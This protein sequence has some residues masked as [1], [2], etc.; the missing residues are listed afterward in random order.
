[1]K[2]KN[3]FSL[4]G[5][6]LMALCLMFG[7]GP[8]VAGIVDDGAGTITVTGD[9]TDP[10]TAADDTT[11]TVNTG[12]TLTTPADAVTF[13]GDGNA[14]VNNGAITATEGNAI[15]VT[16]DNDA[17][18]TQSHTVTNN[19][20]ITGVS[21]IS[22][23][24]DPDLYPN[25]AGVANNDMV[26][27]Y[28]TIEATGAYL[29]GGIESE[30]EPAAVAMGEGADLLNNY[31]GAE[32]TGSVLMGPGDDQIFN[33]GSMTSTYGAAIKM[34]DGSDTLENAG[35]ITAED[36]D[37]AGISMADGDD[38]V[39]NTGT[40]DIGTTSGAGVSMADGD[41]TFREPLKIHF[42]KKA[43]CGGKKFSDWDLSGK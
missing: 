35:T 43:V 15:T 37:C 14:V 12:A 39:T 41:D 24:T 42:L 6:G 2:H 38:T 29:A 19:G 33:W 18:T 26:N 30:E 9:N 31:E 32:I 21:G 27:N 22:F 25:E 7:T 10:I 36:S 40:I 11:V 1:M 34:G 16:Y 20:A 3:R 23:C 4:L 28:G 8:A 17:E 5:I 13:T